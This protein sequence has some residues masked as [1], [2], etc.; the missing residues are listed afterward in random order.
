MAWILTY[1]GRQFWP[2]DPRLED[3]CIEDVAHALSLICRFTGHVRQFY[4]VA[5]HCVL[6]SYLVPEEHALAALLHDASEAYL[7]DVA[8]PVK[9]HPEMQFYLE[10]EAELEL[11]INQKFHVNVYAP[12][13]K[14]V[15]ERLLFT[16]RRD[17][18][19]PGHWTVDEARCYG[20]RITPWPLWQTAERRYLERF[21]SL[22]KGVE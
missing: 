8:R 17:L 3:I 10:A 14:D 22:T 21:R 16:E 9:R 12:E 11:L 13:V 5:Q 4:S 19:P 2:L 6:A 20:A 1:T 18:L 7:C 15:D